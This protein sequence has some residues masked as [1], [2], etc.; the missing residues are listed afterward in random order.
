MILELEGKDAEEQEEKR[1]IEEIERNK[2]E[3]ELMEGID[4]MEVE[5]DE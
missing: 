4:L 1:K 2:V 5:E 3:D